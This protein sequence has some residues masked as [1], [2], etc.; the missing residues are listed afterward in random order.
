MV[1]WVELWVWSGGWNCGRGQLVMCILYVHRSC[2]RRIHALSPASPTHRLYDMYS[3]EMVWSYDD[4][5][6]SPTALWRMVGRAPAV[7][8]WTEDGLWCIRVSG[9]RVY[10]CDGPQWSYIHTVCHVLIILIS[11]GTIHLLL[12]LL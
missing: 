8:L 9:G 7:G 5:E 12:C 6:G 4:H 11:T 2:S 1:R 3:G 10:G